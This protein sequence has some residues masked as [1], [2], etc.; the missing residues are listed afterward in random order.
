MPQ[1]ICMWP[2]AVYYLKP[3]LLKPFETFQQF[4]TLQVYLTDEGH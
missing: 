1:C 4:E 2:K 3:L